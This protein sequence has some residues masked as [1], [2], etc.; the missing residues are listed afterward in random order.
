MLWYSHMQLMK[1][2]YTPLYLPTPAVPGLR[3][4]LHKHMS[5]PEHDLPRLQSSAGLFAGKSRL[6]FGLLAGITGSL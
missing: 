5:G 4:N 3:P 2:S 6:L 1:I